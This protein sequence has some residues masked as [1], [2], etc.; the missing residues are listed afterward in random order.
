MKF[1]Q[2]HSTLNY[3]RI[4]RIRGPHGNYIGK[5]RFDKAN[6]FLDDISQADNITTIKITSL[7]YVNQLLIDSN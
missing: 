7:M 6:G 2:L 4:N 1:V 5:I 3:I